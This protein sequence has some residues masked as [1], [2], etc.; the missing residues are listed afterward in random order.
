MLK[1]DFGVCL[2]LDDSEVQ[3]IYKSFSGPP[4]MYEIK[5]VIELTRVSPE[6]DIVQG[7]YA[8]LIG[9]GSFD[10]LSELRDLTGIKP[11]EET[12]GSLGEL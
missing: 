6:E 12:L 7:W 2:N 8:S 5:D 11:S 4:S 3:A 10:R 9:S 1:R